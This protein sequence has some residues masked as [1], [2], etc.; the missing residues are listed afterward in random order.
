MLELIE[1]VRRLR[2]EGQRVALVALRQQY[3]LSIPTT[4]EDDKPLTPQD[5]ALHN[6]IAD[7]AMADNLL[8][9][10]LLYRR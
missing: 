6:V 8:N 5:N 1:Q 7:R 4:A 2:K 10:A 3:G 9:T